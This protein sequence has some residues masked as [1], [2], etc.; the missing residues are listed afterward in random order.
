MTAKLVCAAVFAPSHVT[1]HLIEMAANKAK[2][3]FE[4]GCAISEFG[5]RRRRSW[6]VQDL[7]VDTLKKTSQ[8]MNSG[9]LTGTSNVNNFTTK[10]HSRCSTAFRFILR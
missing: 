8:S 6:K 4:A 9:K 1:E 5:T 3:M 7:V 10:E 2:R